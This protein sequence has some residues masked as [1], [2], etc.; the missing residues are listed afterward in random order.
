MSIRLAVSYAAAGVFAACLG[1]AVSG[2]ALAQANVLKEC[3]SQY[4]AAKAANELKGQSWQDF[5]KACRTRLSEQP[6]AESA[7]AA[8][9]A[10][11]PAPAP[12]A[13]APKP[14]EPPKTEPPKTEP[15]KAEAPAPA[16]SPL[17]PTAT[18]APTPA[19]AATSAG[20]PVS[21]GMAAFHARQKTCAAEWKAQ[22]AELKKKDPKATWRKYLSECNKRLKPAGQ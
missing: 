22:K 1:V 4:Q 15:P 11:A 16:A 14:L 9:P 3:G 17:K 10:A 6:K 7:P 8:A 13:E 19:P 2:E 12:A 18:P 21:E 5:L 20:K